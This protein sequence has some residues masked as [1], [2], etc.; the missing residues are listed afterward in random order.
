MPLRK[1]ITFS[2]L[3]TSTYGLYGFILVFDKKKG[4]HMVLFVFSFELTD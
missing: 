3:Y 4:P 2:L 1:N